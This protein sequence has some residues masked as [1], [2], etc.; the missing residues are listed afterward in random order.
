MRVF[1]KS[2]FAVGLAIAKTNQELNQLV[3]INQMDFRTET[4]HL[5]FPIVDDGA[6]H[7]TIT[8]REP[9]VD[10]LE[11]IDDLDLVEGGRPKIRQMRSMIAAVADVSDAVIGKLHRNDMIA[12]GELLAPLLEAPAETVIQ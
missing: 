4:Y 1:Q 9:D 2:K 12:L 7:T 6:L 5:R 3:R 10:A 8:L 11:K